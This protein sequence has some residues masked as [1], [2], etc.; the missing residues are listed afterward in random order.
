MPFPYM[1][2]EGSVSDAVMAIA[3]Q[4]GEIV[5]GLRLPPRT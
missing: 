5:C 3:A 4:L 1:Y 2:E